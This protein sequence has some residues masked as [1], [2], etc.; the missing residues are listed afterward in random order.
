LFAT[1]NIPKFTKQQLPC[2]NNAVVKGRDMTTKG[3][4]G[5]TLGGHYHIVEQLGEGGMATVYKAHDTRLQRDVAIKVIRME[6]GADEQFL[7][8]FEREARALARLSHPNIVHV[9]DYG[10][11]DGMPYVVMDYLPGGTLRQKMGQPLPYQEA[12]GLLAPIARALGF[13][14]QM[15]I[16]HRDVKP[17]NILISQSGAPMLSDFGIAK[18]L[19]EET[20]EL[21]GT[22]VGIGTPEYMAPEQGKGIN[23]DYRAD[24]YALGVVFYELVTG[25]KPFRAD[26][27]MAVILKHM[28]EPL[29]RPRTFIPDLP[30]AVEKVIF[31]ALAKRPE[32]RYQTMEEFALALECLARGEKSPAP[33]ETLD[34]GVTRVKKSTAVIGGLSLA[35][36]AGIVVLLVICVL[37]WT[38]GPWNKT[39]PT[40][41]TRQVTSPPGQEYP[42]APPVARATS[43]GGPASLS[44][45]S[46]QMKSGYTQGKIGQGKTADGGSLDSPVGSNFLSVTVMWNSDS[47][48]L[49]LIVTDPDGAQ[50][51]TS[52]PGVQYSSQGKTMTIS[53]D[54]PKPGR[55]K[56]Q[57]TGDQVSGEESFTCMFSANDPGYQTGVLQQQSSSLK[58]MGG[59]GIGSFMVPNGTPLIIVAVTWQDRQAK[60]SVGVRD[61]DNVYITEQNNTYQKSYPDSINFSNGIGSYAVNI[62]NPKPGV[63]YPHVEGLVETP[64]EVT[65][66]LKVT[67]PS[68][69]QP[70]AVP[71]APTPAAPGAAQPAPAQTDSQTEL[72]RKE[73]DISQ[74]QQVDFGSVTITNEFRSF[75]FI[76][77]GQSN[78]KAKVDPVLVDPDGTKV[79]VSYPYAVFKRWG[80]DWIDVS[81]DKPKPGTWK[82]GALTTQVP[83]GGFK[84][85]VTIT[86]YR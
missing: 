33:D 45:G 16:V 22:G 50:V 42:T 84:M 19:E 32:E 8:R 68:G 64:G 78:N 37:A 67:A 51:D 69:S 4:V 48:R 14:H 65:F 73:A 21:T 54:T 56:A 58:G 34:I 25:R 61:P 86:G 74:N 43:P 9:N 57:V 40:G 41:V 59:V 39:A 29:P 18:M 66:E 2:I 35:V 28:T 63:W 36:V 70:A 79:E 49:G 71:Q 80:P 15:H 53:V 27:P 11:Q 38:F 81:I 24:I 26:T 85:Y 83:P 12:A 52:Y 31:K 44:Q 77:Y 82:L 72:F 6:K 46:I 7:K 20:S 13:A 10:E 60:L 47:S 5:F 55:W 3:L 1:I 30:D 17:P 75:T 76:L 62:K 23:V